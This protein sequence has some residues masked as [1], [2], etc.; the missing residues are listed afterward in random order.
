MKRL[1]GVPFIIILAI[2]IIWTLGS[3]GL[4]QTVDAQSSIPGA[5]SRLLR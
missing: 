1:R 5:L 2:L 3:V 4:N